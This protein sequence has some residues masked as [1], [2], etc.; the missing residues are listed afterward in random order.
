[1]AMT[2]LSLLEPQPKPHIS[3]VALGIGICMIAFGVFSVL[4]RWRFHGSAFPPTTLRGMVAIPLGVAVSCM[5]WGRACSA[6]ATKLVASKIRTPSSRA[7]QL[8][9][10]LR[11]GDG[12]AAAGAYEET[13]K[14][15][16]NTLITAHVCPDCRRLVLLR[17]NAGEGG[18]LC[19]DVAIPLADAILSGRESS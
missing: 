3:W 11:T 19:G 2:R 14:E 12:L 13:R 4:N 17:T 15:R 18:V 16:G 6:C 1:M 8:L 9:M 10:F 5:A 7:H